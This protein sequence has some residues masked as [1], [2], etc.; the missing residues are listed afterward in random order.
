[1]SDLFS[2]W[3][4]PDLNRRPHVCVRDSGYGISE[5]VMEGIAKGKV[6]SRSIG[7]NNV[8]QRLKLLYGTGLQ[9]TRL[10]PGTAVCFDLPI[11][12]EA[13]CSTR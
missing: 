1:M 6:E 13:T 9:L 5:E 3:R 7:L 2:V 11:A 12:A 10:E 8:N 4:E